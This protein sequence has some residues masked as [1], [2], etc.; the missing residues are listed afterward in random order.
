MITLLVG[1]LGPTQLAVDV[2]Y[3]AMIPMYFM[4][5]RGFGMAG[6]SR[7]GTLIGENKHS[8][9]HR[10]GDVI[11]KFTL[12][13]TC[14]VAALSYLMRGYIPL[15]FTSDEEVIDMAVKLSPLFCIFIIPHGMQGSF[16]GLLRGIKRQGKS[17]FAVLIG[18]WFVSIPLACSLA[19]YPTTNMQ[20]FGM[21]AGNNVGYYVMDI[22]FLYLWITYDWNKEEN[23][24]E[25]QPLL[26]NRRERKAVSV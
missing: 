15:L 26:G 6:A 13:E 12:F 18:P 3:S 25:R 19:F 22:I 23:K 21:W 8:L 20:I 16:Q 5:P 11:L 7:V 10:L 2:I 4:I 24:A 17:V 1:L 9:A 14:A